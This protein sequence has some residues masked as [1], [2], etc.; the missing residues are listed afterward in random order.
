MVAG[1]VADELSFQFDCYL[2]V[3]AMVAGLWR[4]PC[5][6]VNDCRLDSEKENNERNRTRHP[7]LPIAENLTVEQ[8]HKSRHTKLPIVF[9]LAATVQSYLNERTGC[10]ESPGPRS[11]NR[12]R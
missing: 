2:R 11:H 10:T 8:L 12:Y 7:Q 9:P 5:R 6:G 4:F 3:R 1:R